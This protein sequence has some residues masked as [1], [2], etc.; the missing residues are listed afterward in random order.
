MLF[1]FIKPNYSNCIFLA[2]FFY[3]H[4]QANLFS[5]GPNMKLLEQEN[6]FSMLKMF[7]KV[8]KK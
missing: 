4:K 2:S 5:M 7:W 8:K 6:I 3:F 1:L